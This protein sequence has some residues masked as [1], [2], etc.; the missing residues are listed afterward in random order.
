MMFTMKTLPCILQST[1]LEINV[2]VAFFTSRHLH[3][4]TASIL[5]QHSSDSEAETPL[6][7][8]M[9]SNSSVLKDNPVCGK[10]M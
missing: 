6:D 4:L 10:P 8:V 2:L 1:M 7:T 9:S 3:R 5:C